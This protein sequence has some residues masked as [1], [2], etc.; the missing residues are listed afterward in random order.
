MMI[1]FLKKLFTSL[2]WEELYGILLA[3]FLECFT[4]IISIH[5]ISSM[6]LNSDLYAPTVNTVSIAN[7]I[8]CIFSH[9]NV[10][11]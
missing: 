11:I 8:N 1:D 3:I 2:F 7:Y 9:G 4:I 6:K 5:F 10:M